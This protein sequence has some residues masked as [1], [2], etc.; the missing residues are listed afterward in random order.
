MTDISDEPKLDVKANPS[1]NPVSAAISPGN[2]S[3]TSPRVCVS[4]S[5]EQSRAGQKSVTFAS[6]LGR[7]RGSAELSRSPLD[8]SKVDDHVGFAPASDD[9]REPNAYDGLA[10]FE[11]GSL[12]DE[13][14]S[15][16][17]SG[18]RNNDVGPQ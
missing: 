17:P 7:K 5:A 12:T 4:A 6:I 3:V 13:H 1:N 8:F 9:E 10:D 14:S 2:I 15:S 18:S 16:V 11:E